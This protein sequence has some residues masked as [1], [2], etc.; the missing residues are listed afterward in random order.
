MKIFKQRSGK[1]TR[2]HRAGAT[3]VEFSLTLPILLL[4]L[5]ATYEL[6]TGNMMLNTTEAAA[7]EGAR[8]AII[9]GATAADAEA[10]AQE[11]LRTA[12]IDTYTLTVQPQNLDV[13][14]ETVEVTIDV[15]Y[16]ENSLF[17]PDFLDGIRFVRTCVLSRENQ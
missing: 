12:G 9:P 13:A 11:V 6:G 1:Q 4:F 14:S 3:A 8:I 7:Y 5:F 16:A 2:A 15:S 17:V 10:A